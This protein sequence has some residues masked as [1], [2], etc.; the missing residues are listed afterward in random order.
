MSPNFVTL[1]LKTS[2]YK[3]KLIV[4]QD[5]ASLVSEH[6]RSDTDFMDGHLVVSVSNVP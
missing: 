2:I 5:C 6:Y 3:S 4:I 1:M